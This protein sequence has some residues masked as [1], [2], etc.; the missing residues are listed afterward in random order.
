MKFLSSIIPAIITTFLVSCTT[1][2]PY[3]SAMKQAEECMN[4]RP[5]SA[6]VLLESMT[7]SIFQYPE[8]TQMYWHLLTIQA[9]DKQYIAHTSDSLINRIVEFYETHNDNDKLMMAYY[10]QG[11]V[12]RDMNDAPRALKAFQKVLNVDTPKNDLQTKTYNQRGKLFAYQGL[13]DEAIQENRNFIDVYTQQGKIY[14]TSYALRD[15]ARMHDMKNNRD[16]TL[17]YYKLACQTALADKDS[18]RFYSMIGE[19]GGYYCELGKIDSSKLILKYA[20]R[21]SIIKNKSHIYAML[22]YVY[23][24]QENQ[25]SAYY[26]YLKSQESGDIRHTYYSYRNLFDAEVQKGNYKEAVSYIDKALQ[27]KDSIDQITRTEEIA[28]INSLYNYQHTEAE[29]NR[30]QLIQE[31][32]KAQLLGLLLVSLAGATGGIFYFLRQKEKRR[33]VLEAAEKFKKDAKERYERSQ[34]AIEDNENKIKELEAQLTLAKE[35]CDLLKAEQLQV[36]QKRLQTRNEEIALQQE[37]RKLRIA[38]FRRSAIYKV[39]QRATQTQDINMAHERSTPKW[40]ELKVAIDTAYPD[41][42]ERLHDLCPSLSDKETKVCLLAKADITP[43]E[44]AEILSITR[45]AV[46]NIRTRIHQKVQKTG[47]E[48]T[49]FDHFIESLI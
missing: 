3:P 28:K 2:T 26:Y 7:D 14:K 4:T 42:S 38:A 11:S 49:N 20:E 39:F 8:E 36:Q 33:K 34:K 27:L 21:Q 37:E 17:H 40:E 16:S 44:I 31:R 9:K 47:G 35:E 22:G 30:L 10:Y 6:L 15:I 19:L 18:A 29:N 5:D 48:F 46:T 32:Q 41:F 25:D 24:I 13:Y 43:S 45:Q 1:S 23:K 12:Y